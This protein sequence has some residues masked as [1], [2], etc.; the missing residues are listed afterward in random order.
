MITKHNF[1]VKEKDHKKRVDLIVVS[2]YSNYSRSK[3]NKIIKS[4]LLKALPNDSIGTLWSTLL[5]FFEGLK[6]TDKDGESLLFKNEYFFIIM[7][8][9]ILFTHRENVK[10]LINKEESKTKIY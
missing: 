9:L 2:N 3:I 6:P 4:S 8:V 5:K 1:I 10:R 7:F